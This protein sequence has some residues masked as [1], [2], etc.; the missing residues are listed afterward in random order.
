MRRIFV[1]A[2]ITLCVVLFTVRRILV[3]A[4]II[5]CVCCS[6]Y[7]AYIGISLYHTLCCDVHCETYIGIGL[8]HTLCSGF[9]YETYIGINLYL[10]MYSG[11]HYETYIL[12]TRPAELNQCHNLNTRTLSGPLPIYT[13]KKST[14]FNMAVTKKCPK[15]FIDC[16]ENELS[17]R[18]CN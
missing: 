14:F 8:Y 5:L 9:H 10:I 13:R 3:S 18:P 1:S 11:S 2:Y 12:R 4:H 17:M 7:E 6:H 15:C 16:V